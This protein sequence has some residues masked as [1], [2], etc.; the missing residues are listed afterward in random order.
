MVPH[1]IVLPTNEAGDGSIAMLR[2]GNAR[3]I[4]I[5][6]IQRRHTVMTRGHFRQPFGSCLQ[7]LFG[8]FK[9]PSDVVD[10]DASSVATVGAAAGGG[11]MADLRHRCT[12]SKDVQKF[13]GA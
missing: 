8:L 13:S 5:G 1:V 9:G 10:T 6:G 11:R 3:L 7:R 4:T 12:A 2:R